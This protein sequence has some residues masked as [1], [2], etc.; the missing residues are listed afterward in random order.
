V[1][2]ARPG[3]AGLRSEQGVKINSQNVAFDDLHVGRQSKL[4]S[5][6]GGENAVEF[7]GDKSA[8]SPGK[9]GTEGTPSRAYFENG[10]AREVRERVHDANG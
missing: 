2:H 6:L 5:Q 9:K 8:G 4:H 10:F 3:A 7:D 1:L